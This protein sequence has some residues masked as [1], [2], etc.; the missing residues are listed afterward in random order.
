MYTEERNY[1]EQMEQAKKDG[2]AFANTNNKYY[3]CEDN[4]DIEKAKSYGYTI[5]PM[6]KLE[7]M[8]DKYYDMEFLS[9]V[10]LTKFYIKQ[11]EFSY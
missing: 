10:K 9:N 8:F 4:E 5:Y 1:L 11:G 7:T 2:I 6:E 3:I